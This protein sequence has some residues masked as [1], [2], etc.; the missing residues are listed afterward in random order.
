MPYRMTLLWT[1]VLGPIVVISLLGWQYAEVLKPVV[2]VALTNF[3]ALKLVLRGA[4]FGTAW[5][6][7]WHPILAA[8]HV[9]H[10]NDGRDLYGTLFFETGLRFQYPPTVLLPFDF[11]YSLGMLGPKVL[12][13]LNFLV[14]CLNAIAAGFLASLL[15]RSKP[16]DTVDGSPRLQ[17]EF[18]S[19]DMAVLT[20]MVAFLFYP[21]QRAQVLGQIQIWIDAL[22]TLAILFWICRRRFLAGI[23]VGLA[24]TIKPQLGLL[25]IWG[26]MWREA[27]FSFGIVSVLAPIAALSLWRYG[28][29][30]HLSYLQVLSFLS[31]HGEVFFANNSVN[32]IL[33]SYFAPTDNLV[34]DPDH[35]SPYVPIVHAGTVVASVIFFGLLIVPPYLLRRRRPEVADLGAASICTVLGS[36]I[37]WD[38]HYGILFPLYLVAL[39][40]VAA[41][42][43]GKRRLVSFGA[44]LVSWILVAD[45]IPFANL[46]AHTPFSFM[47]A[48]QFFGALILLAILVSYQ[49]GRPPR[50]GPSRSLRPDGDILV[51]TA[52]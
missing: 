43:P 16:Q 11:Q 33:H 2:P 30:A 8:V 3:E 52:A 38:H 12:N 23:C 44:L 10:S 41:F 26:I 13:A 18:N 20:I 22:F 28:F 35:L 36:P 51:P 42:P 40:L 7:S 24:C 1:L 27:A 21:L 31:A 50:S 48:N 34:W 19:L 9:V 45:F 15:F 14:Y 37:A 39:K 47:L 5:G 17:G 32:G 49:A 29:S 6:D 25:L 46:S 4:V